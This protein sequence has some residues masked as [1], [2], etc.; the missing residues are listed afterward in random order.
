MSSLKRI[1]VVA[2]TIIG[3]SPLWGAESVAMENKEN[4]SPDSI[5][6]KKENTLKK[7]I[8]AIAGD[9]KKAHEE[10]DVKKILQS[11]Q[12][13]KKLK[14]KDIEWEALGQ[15]LRVTKWP[16]QANWK[17]AV[18]GDLF[19][20]KKVIDWE[21][22]STEA[23]R[24]ERIDTI[25]ALVIG[26]KFQHPFSTYYLARIL[27]NIHSNYTDAEKPDLFL[28]LYS[29]AFRNLKQYQE[30]SDTCYMLG[31]SHF[32]TGALLD[33]LDH[34]RSMKYH[35]KGK[36]L[37]DQYQILIIRGLYDK[38]YT[39][40]VSEDYLDLA[41]KGH[42][43]AY[44]E[45][46]RLLKEVDKKLG[47]LNEAVGNGYVSALIGIGE[48]YESLYKK[49][50][51]TKKHDTNIEALLQNA[52]EHYQKAGKQGV[53]EGY[54]RLGK[55]YVGD[56]IF[57]NS[58]E[59]KEKFNSL[60]LET[61]ENAVLCFKQAGEMHNPQGW[62][63]LAQL[64]HNLYQQAESEARKM[65]YNLSGEWDKKKDIYSQQVYE[66]L[67]KGIALGSQSAY[68]MAYRI[69]SPEAFKEIYIK[70]GPAPQEKSFREAI[71]KF[72]QE[73]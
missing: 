29:K 47:V 35:S 3:A 70:Y 40:P 52:R 53:S 10:A 46:A 59:L 73:D 4:C 15:T 5:I 51:S 48:I 60:P 18:G 56:I 39:P 57:D 64:Y 50:P 9:I 37:K 14:T 63:Y 28:D 69:F 55:T 38:I 26:A 31:R 1:C 22:T 58:Y 45:A 43:L 12:A 41:R 20:P 36:S 7:H 6:Y 19:F 54:I 13:F 2:F 49:S 17:E 44:L 33:R 42:Q 24:L 27:D 11:Y 67:Q 72:L 61:I 23:Y 71:E 21:V 30:I 34:A 8:T 25:W 66:F 16:S 32:S 65:G 62:D 68:D